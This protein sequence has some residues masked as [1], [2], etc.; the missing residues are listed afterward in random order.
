MVVHGAGFRRVGY[1]AAGGIARARAGAVWC[2]VRGSL[3]DGVFYYRRWLCVSLYR[4][5]RFFRGDSAAF[6]GG[7]LFKAGQAGRYASALQLLDNA[8]EAFP[9]FFIADYVGGQLRR[10]SIQGRVVAYV[11]RACC[12]LPVVEGEEV[13][14]QF[15][16][17]GGI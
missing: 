7:K 11:H 14:G 9:V 4:W 15:E 2:G 12:C 8:V 5:W 13:E 3:W 1:V 16:H 6:A 10:V 17:A